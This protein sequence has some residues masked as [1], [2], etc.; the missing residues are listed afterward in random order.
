MSTNTDKAI[1]T[2]NEDPDAALEA[3]LV[4]V[5]VYKIPS[6]LSQYHVGYIPEKRPVFSIK[7]MVTKLRKR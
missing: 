6:L 2:K 3:S 4:E 7:N 5:G 1:E